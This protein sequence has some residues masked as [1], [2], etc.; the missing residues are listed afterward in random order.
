MFSC[1]AWRTG[2]GRCRQ[3]CHKQ[4]L[5]LHSGLY[6]ILIQPYVH[7]KKCLPKRPAAL[8]FH[9][10]S[11]STAKPA[12][13]AVQYFHKA[14]EG[15]ERQN[16]APVTTVLGITCCEHQRGLHKQPLQFKFS[17]KYRKSPCTVKY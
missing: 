5:Q 7:E 12:V 13:N 8:V 1:G 4:N 2:I 16:D 15:G 11:L 14:K 10:S 9:S 17:I 6:T 3:F